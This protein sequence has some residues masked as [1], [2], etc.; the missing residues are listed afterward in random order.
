MKWLSKKEIADFNKCNVTDVQLDT[1]GN[2]HGK[3]TPSIED[4]LWRFVE[5]LDKKIRVNAI[6]PGPIWTPLI[7]ATTGGTKEE[8]GSGQ[9]LGRGGEAYECAP[10]YVYLASEDSSYVTGQTIHINGGEIVNG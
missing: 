7:P 5:F 3:L 2:I 1:N 8:H 6:A 9:P 4:R 10:A